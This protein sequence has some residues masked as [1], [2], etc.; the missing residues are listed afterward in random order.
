MLPALRARHGQQTSA[1]MIVTD[2]SVVGM[3]AA[4]AVV[5]FAGMAGAIAWYG[6]TTAQRRPPAP[7][8]VA[9]ATLPRTKPRLMPHAQLVPAPVE[10]KIELAPQPVV[11]QPPAPERRRISPAVKK[12]TTVRARFHTKKPN[13]RVAAKTK[14]PPPPFEDPFAFVR[15]SQLSEEEL[16]C[17]L[18]KFAREVDLDSERG[19]AKKIWEESHKQVSQPNRTLDSRLS[20]PLRSLLANRVD[21]HG[22]P[23]RFEADCQAS[24]EVAENLSEYSRLLRRAMRRNLDPPEPSDSYRQVEQI[25]DA[26]YSLHSTKPDVATL[27]Q[28][29]QAED[30]PLRRLMLR[31]LA[32]IPGPEATAALA[33][34]ALFDLSAAL[35]E[36]AV[37][38]LKDRRPEDYRLV[39][40]QGLRYPWAPV[41]DHAA[42]AL[43]TLG[44]RG[45]LPQLVDILSRPDPA[46]PRLE[47]A[48]Q[49]VVPEIV[50]VNHLRNCLLCHAP[51]LDRKDPVRGLVPTPGEPLREAYYDS[52]DGD[53]VRAD[54]TYLRQDFSLK[55]LVKDAKPWP[56]QQRFD[57]LVRL[58]PLTA[59]EVKQ[60]GLHD[61]SGPQ[62]ARADY[63]QR[64]AVLYALKALAAQEVGTLAEK[65]QRLLP[66][67]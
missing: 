1:E 57:Y 42:E 9:Q 14:A 58:R 7:A 15:R 24:K 16:T 12:P 18:S 55:Q 64:D 17:A 6:V 59:A 2:W 66:S 35:R 48:G 63:P 27:F 28:V 49:W 56:S 8:P 31:L 45:A 21:L 44:D 65:W 4:I 20:S 37:A 43:V 38:V 5:G 36:T 61:R 62:G 26:V 41:A 52:F 60:R 53:F 19:T 39:L 22:L 25:E 3:M 13:V 40:L 46:A 23:I 11:L 33:R 50:R 30:E 67:G 47:K 54:I 51:S 32:G 10:P 29:L 34:R